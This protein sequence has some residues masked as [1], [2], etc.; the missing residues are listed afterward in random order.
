M[1]RCS[2]D[3]LKPCPFCGNMPSLEFDIIA[4]DPVICRCGNIYPEG[5]RSRKH[6]KGLRYYGISIESKDGCGLTVDLCDI[7]LE[8]FD[9][10]LHNP[11]LPEEAE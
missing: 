4:I 1:W 11:A 7:C 5:R 2:V 9:C 8:S 3:A 6:F 10:W